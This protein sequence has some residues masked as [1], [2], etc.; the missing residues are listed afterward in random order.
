MQD[1]ANL[2]RTISENLKFLQKLQ[3][4]VT[5]KCGRPYEIT[6]TYLLHGNRV[7]LEKLTGFAFMEPGSSLPYSQVFATCPYPEPA[8]S[9]PHSP[10]PLPE[11]PS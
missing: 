11:D 8:P 1:D 7:L 2:E 10:L 5:T 4:F 6:S 3:P 9:S